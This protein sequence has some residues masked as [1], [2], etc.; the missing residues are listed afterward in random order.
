[1]SKTTPRVTP[2]DAARLHAWA[3]RTWQRMLSGRRLNLVDPSP[4][5][6]E[7]SDIA[8]GLSRNTRW[9]GQTIGDHGWSVAQH[10]DF[11]VD[12]VR[13]M[14]PRAPAWLLMAAKLHDASEYVTHDLI[15]P[16]KHVVGDVF[17]EVE[18]RIQCAVHLRFGLPQRVDAE[19]KALIKRADLAAA[20]TEAV[21]LAGFTPEEVTTVLGFREK[22]QEV[23]LRP[24]SSRE[25][26]RQFLDG[27][28]YL[29]KKML[30]EGK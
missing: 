5:D 29:A 19:T 18:D 16:L 6:I 26:E 21:Q 4:L 17:K 9:N 23:T 14:K 10:S 7:I 2:E 22:P 1:M 3:P 15:T 28:D 25:A 8:L 24:L 11:V 20:A 12:I 30:I 27:F 13:R